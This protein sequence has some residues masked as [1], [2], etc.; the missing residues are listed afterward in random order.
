MDL[1]TYSDKYDDIMASVKSILSFVKHISEDRDSNETRQMVLHFIRA[2]SQ[3]LE[4]SFLVSPLY[5]VTLDIK[6]MD[7]LN[8]VED[9]RHAEKLPIHCFSFG[10]MV[11]PM[12]YMV[13][14]YFNVLFQLNQSIS[15]AKSL[16]EDVSKFVRIILSSDGWS[17]NLA[18]VTTF[19]YGHLD[20]AC[21]NLWKAVALGL[22]DILDGQNS[23]SSV[24]LVSACQSTIVHF[25][26]YPVQAVA[27]HTNNVESHR[28]ALKE[29][30]PSIRKD[31]NQ[32]NIGGVWVSLFAA[33]SKADIE[34]SFGNS[35]RDILC[36][37]LNDFLQRNAVRLVVAESNS[38]LV[39]HLLSLFG[40]MLTSVLELILTN[41]VYANGR[42]IWTG[43]VLPVTLRFMEL[44]MADAAAVCPNLQ[45]LNSRV[46]DSLGR[47]AQRINSKQDVLLFIEIFSDPLALWLSQTKSSWSDCILQKL[48]QLSFKALR[49][50]TR[51]QPKIE[52]NSSLLKVQARLLEQTLR[53]SKQ[54]IS[55][56]AVGL[57]NSTYGV[58]TNLDYPKTLLPILDSL[59]RSDRIYLGNVRGMHQT[60]TMTRNRTSKRVELAAPDHSSK[61]MARKKQKGTELTEHQKEVRAAQ[62]GRSMDCEGR[63]PGVR[64]YTILDF[65]Q[66]NEDS[67]EAGT[68][69]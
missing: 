47:V 62:L 16:E 48:E 23:S 61:Q 67:Q 57:W 54:S 30:L 32:N 31:L 69:E 9:A 12:A 42:P 33:I 60:M 58:Q 40:I 63:G 55:D 27:F 38:N 68:S 11:C 17:E 24:Q 35:C 39:T 21:V 26:T 19:F 52:F 44:L 20:L 15:D 3:E 59:W 49:C 46:L 25:L 6:Y 66:G 1:K 2:I 36:L 28:D 56:P 13:I 18:I 43:G 37:T 22:R 10:D 7:Q 34:D 64:T 29:F 41:E 5:K 51:S 4:P 65:S 14:L 53:H 50:S 45:D 8:L